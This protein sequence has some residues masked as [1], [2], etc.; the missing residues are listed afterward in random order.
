MTALP[1][2]DVQ[3][4][5]GISYGAVGGAAYKTA[6]AAF[7][8]GR[9][10]RNVT[11]SQARMS[12]DVSHGVK[13]QSEMDAL[14]AFFR[15]RKGKG[16]GF[17]FKD[18][19][20]Y[21]VPPGSALGT[22]DGTTRIFQM[23]KTYSADGSSS[24]LWEKR[25]IT[26][27]VSGTVTM[28]LNGVTQSGSAFAVDY[29]TGKVTFVTAPGSGVAV[30]GGCQFDVPVRFNTDEMKLTIEDYN[31]LSWGSISVVELKEG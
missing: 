18:W 2:H 13:T 11:W 28:A 15:N 23:V 26:R 17:R 22:G 10:Q 4:P 19:S 7:N 12:W 25:I 27:P 5:P 30:T 20:D 31:I 24:T 14:I 9:E 16:Y 21:I 29:S 3:F 1:F 8:N 6:I